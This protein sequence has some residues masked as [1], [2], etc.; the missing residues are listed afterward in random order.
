LPI[1]YFER[2]KK[3][4]FVPLRLRQ[5]EVAQQPFRN[6]KCEKR[7][8]VSI[9]IGRRMARDLLSQSVNGAKGSGANLFPEGQI[10]AFRA[11]KV[12]LHF[13]HTRAPSLLI[14]RVVKITTMSDEA[15]PGTGFQVSF[16]TLAACAENT[17][18]F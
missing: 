13:T 14:L 18:D 2:R 4:C 16:F 7:V 10:I 1:K 11:I 6:I 17:F 15:F 3:K 8:S 5:L 9:S 12:T